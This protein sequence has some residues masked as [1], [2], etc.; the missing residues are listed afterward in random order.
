MFVQTEIRSVGGTSGANP[1]LS[2]VKNYAYDY[3]GNVTSQNDYDWVSYPSSGYWVNSTMTGPPSLPSSL[4]RTTTNSYYVTADL[5][6]V[7]NGYWSTGASVPSLLDAVT[8]KEVVEDGHPVAYSEYVYD[9]ATTTGNVT[10]ELQWDSVQAPAFPGAQASGTLSGSLTQGSNAIAVRRTYTSGDL[11]Q[12][13]DPKGTNKLYV[14]SSASP[15]PTDLYLAY[16]TANQRHWSFVWDTTA[17]LRTSET[18]VDNSTVTNVSYDPRGRVTSAD[19]AGQQRTI[20]C[21]DDSALVTTAVASLYRPT[22]VSYPA[23][24]STTAGIR[25]IRSLDDV[26]RVWQTQA[27][28][29]N[30]GYVTSQSFQQIT[31]GGG[32]TYQLASNPFRTTGDATMGW[33]RSKLDPLGRVVEVAHFAGAGMPSPWGTSGTSAGTATTSYNG[34]VTTVADEALNKRSLASDAF[35]RLVQVIEDPTTLAYSTVYNYCLGNLVGVSQTGAT[36]TAQTSSACAGTNTPGASG[37]TG[38]GRSFSYSSLGRLLTAANPES[39]SISYTYDA[40]GNLI[41]RT[42]ARRIITCFGALA[43]SACDGCGFDFLIRAT[44]KVYSDG[45]T[46]GT[47]FTYDDPSVPCSRGRLTKATTDQVGSLASVIRSITSYNCVG[48]ITAVSQ[49]VGSNPARTVTGIVYN[50]AGGMTQEVLPSGRTVSYGYD[51][52][53]RASSVTG[54]INGNSTPYAAMPTTPANS[55]YSAAGALQNWSMGNGVSEV[56]SF[57]SRLQPV[58]IAAHSTTGGNAALQLNLYYC[59][60][61]LLDCPGNNGNLQEQ[62]IHDPTG[63]SGTAVETYYYDALNRLCGA[64]EAATAG[65]S[66]ACSSPLSGNNWQQNYVYDAFGNR[67][68]LAGGYG[69]TGNTQAQV[70]SISASAVA[71]I[72]ANNRWSGA[73]P[74]AGG[75]VVTLYVGGP[76]AVYDGENRISSM[77]EAS[78]PGISYQYDGEGRRVLKT[79]GSTTTEYVYGAAGELVAEYGGNAPV[80]SPTLYLTADHLGSTRMV[81]NGSGTV[82][83]LRDYA[84]FGEELG[85]GMGPRPGGSTLY[86]GLAY[87]SV[88][89]DANNVNFTSKD[90]DAESGNDFFGARYYGS[91]MGRFMS[92]DLPVDQHPADP[93]SWN[94]YSYVRNNPLRMTDPTGD[95]ACGTYVSAEQCTAFGNMLT[96]AQATLDKAKGSGSIDSDQYKTATR[97]LGAYGALNDGNGVTVNVGATGGFPGTTAA[98]GGGENTAANPTGQDIQVTLNK[99]LFDQGSSPGLLGAIAHEGSHVED[100]EAW[101]KAGFSAAANPTNFQTEFAAYGVTIAV[102][103]AQGATALS[104]TKPGGNTSMMF[105]NGQKSSFENQNM[106]SNMIKTF[107]PNWAIKAF[108]ENTKGSGWGTK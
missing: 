28:D 40:N 59:G 42:D 91:S 20:T 104:G 27:T 80:V 107:Y 60:S 63:L 56:T 13:T 47:T 9:S 62:D 18:D 17:G 38:V 55:A 76:Q 77:T 105:W 24:C 92:P 6:A 97:A 4:S 51:G 67:A 46:P 82:T 73:T 83:E 68:L 96:Q 12:E 70:G 29:D 3:N 2:A 74:D 75:N 88:T 5:T 93:Q 49:Q 78:M 10:T 45:T 44:R 108:G 95:Y 7:G 87:P 1:V 41:K 103:Q 86:T 50:F 23:D 53:G 21:Y 58:S 39:G 100:A 31:A 99:K 66:V 57:N 36:G 25:S 43:G 34:N 11:T 30:S 71:G 35:G 54:V 52:A 69:T 94:L 16:G 48:R 15:Y 61:Q 102:A 65:G 33:T 19:Q 22:L 98:E 79:V 89:A 90:R 101:A 8:S 85:A 81:T 64:A 72:F 37:S 84:P 32:Y 26:G 14:Y 106:R